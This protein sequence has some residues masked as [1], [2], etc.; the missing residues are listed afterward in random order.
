M[1]NCSTA[2]EALVDCV[3][4]EIR[5]NPRYEKD[6]LIE[7]IATSDLWKEIAKRFNIRFGKIQ[8]SIHDGR[9]SKFAN[10]DLKFDTEINTILSK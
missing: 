4:V 1:K 9:P 7:D 5:N 6:K 2:R 10:V 8:M 3:T